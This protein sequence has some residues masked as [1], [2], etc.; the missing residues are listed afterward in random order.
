MSA[1]VEINTGNIVY[2]SGD[3]D[4][5]DALSWLSVIR[6][7]RLQRARNKRFNIK[8]FGIINNCANYRD[9]ARE[10]TG[11][12]HVRQT[13]DAASQLRPLADN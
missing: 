9:F 13:S 4:P 10:I 1:T 12:L 7:Q 6:H 2:E 8:G 3:E 5:A 11:L